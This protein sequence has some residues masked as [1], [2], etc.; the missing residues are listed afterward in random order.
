M[1]SDDTVDWESGRINSPG[2][3]E[4][5]ETPFQHETLSEADNTLPSYFFPFRGN[6]KAITYDRDGDYGLTAPHISKRSVDKNWLHPFRAFKI[7]LSDTS[8]FGDAIGLHFECNFY[9][10]NCIY[11][12]F[13]DA[14]KSMKYP[15]LIKSNNAHQSQISFKIQF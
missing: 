6:S 8:A 7:D 4:W 2:L 13:D 5:S 11:T 10:A 9:C 3:I 1:K 14:T 15:D 12:T